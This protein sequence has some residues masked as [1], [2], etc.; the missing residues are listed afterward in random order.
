MGREKIKYSFGQYVTPEIVDLILENP[1][2]QW[3][4]GL[5]VDA[6][7]LFVDIRG[8]TTLAEEK[9]PETIV[10]LLND[11]F[12]RITDIVIKHGGHLNKFVGD[13]AM[14]VFGTHQAGGNWVL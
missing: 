13:E 5:K 7:V 14:A 12:T 3:M 2:N 8:F 10:E 9:D 1:D 11:H 4:K 6:T